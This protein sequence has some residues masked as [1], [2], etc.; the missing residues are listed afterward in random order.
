MITGA[1]GMALLLMVC[2]T[3]GCSELFTNSCTCI[4]DRSK[5][6]SVHT[7][8]KKVI[9]SKENLSD[10]PD[11]RVLP[12]RTVHLI[13]SNNK[14]VVL[15]NDSFLGLYA[16]EKLDLKNNL[17]STIMPGA[18]HGLTEM[19]RLDLSNNR[20]GCLIPAIFHSLGELNRL[21][22][23]G[24]IF[25]NL[26]PN[27]FDPLVSLK[28]VDFNTESLMC[29]CNMQWVLNW[30]RNSSARISEATVCAYPRALQGQ[31]FKSLKESQLGC[32]GPLELPTLQLIPSL[33]QVVFQ[34][35]RLPFQCTATYIDNTTQVLWYH[36]SAPVRPEAESGLTVE[37]SMIHDC[38]FISSELILS[39]IYLLASGEWECVIS[40]SRGNSSRKVE[41]VV[42]ETSASYC[43]AE[44][45]TNNRGEFRW[46][47]TL[48][49]IVSYQLCLQ[50][51]SFSVIRPSL[52]K[53]ASRRC[54]RSGQWETGD[55]SECL[56]INDY[57]RTLH[58]FT[59]VIRGNSIIMLEA[60]ER[61]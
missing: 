55:Y 21:N 34:G 53:K 16:L 52:E 39:N 46:P 33:R 35:D 7:V 10:P 44:H 61:V 17:I 32:D 36:N 43:P 1:V 23:S 50:Y 19:K 29:D 47:R 37:D 31:Q 4:D 60:L 18:F 14:I 26:H 6:P 24:N 30:E 57:T 42:L 8:R 15:K 25:S 22:L 54:G 5:G 20:I 40:T 12:N 48:S 38:S 27:L 41:I 28:L 56:Y 49:G 59:R 51:P 45:V 13:L 58:I 9:C 3:D 11:P 2:Q